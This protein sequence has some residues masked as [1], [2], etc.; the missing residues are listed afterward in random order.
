MTEQCHLLE[1]GVQVLFVAEEED[2]FGGEGK[3]LA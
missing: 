3:M 1:C 2:F